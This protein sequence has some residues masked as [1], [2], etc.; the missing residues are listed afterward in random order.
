ME[1]NNERANR[2]KKEVD[3]LARQHCL[4]VMRALLSRDNGRVFLW[5]LLQL[6]KW[7]VQ[8]FSLDSNAMSFACG[9]TNVGN[10]IMAE[11]L[12]A[13]PEGFVRMMKENAD[14]GRNLERRLAAA[15]DEPEPGDDLI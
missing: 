4:D 1:A 3:D 12:E 7:N 2:I 9:E 13:D 5:H 6:G 14:A 8:P 15:S 11:I 10:A